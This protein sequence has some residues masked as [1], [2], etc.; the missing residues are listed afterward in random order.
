MVGQALVGLTPTP[1]ATVLLRCVFHQFSPVIEK[2]PP[3][4]SASLQL[5]VWFGFEGSFLFT[6]YKKQGFESPKP[7]QFTGNWSHTHKTWGFLW[8]YPNHQGTPD[9]WPGCSGVRNVN[10]KGSELLNSNCRLK[11]N[12]SNPIQWSTRL[13]QPPPM[14]AHLPQGPRNKSSAF[15]GC[16]DHRMV[17]KIGKPKFVVSGRTALGQ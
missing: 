15:L 9:V 14:L 4:L 7:P 11:G 2:G 16:Q 10:S 8:G 1:S 17:T 5:I 12:P 3:C 13:L 6:L